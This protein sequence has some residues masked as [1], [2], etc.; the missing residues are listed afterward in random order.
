[1]LLILIYFKL[2]LSQSFKLELSEGKINVI[3][4]CLK[5][6]HEV[7]QYAQSRRQNYQ[8]NWTVKHRTNKLPQL[9]F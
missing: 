1:M 8:R 9:G 7:Y 4:P 3:F 2:F 6:E 5:N